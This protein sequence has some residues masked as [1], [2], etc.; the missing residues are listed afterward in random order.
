[1]TTIYLP[2]AGS[3]ITFF[4]LDPLCTGSSLAMTFMSSF[5]GIH[6]HLRR[7]A[8]GIPSCIPRH[9]TPDYEVLLQSRG[10]INNRVLAINAWT[11]DLLMSLL[12]P[13]NL[14]GLKEH[15]QTADECESHL[16]PVHPTSVIHR[17][18]YDKIT[19]YDDIKQSTHAY[20][21][22]ENY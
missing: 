21:I 6:V 4:F 13:E 2:S 17:C 22:G 12:L 3:C 18:A 7:L 8:M 14:G 1:M 19:S 16:R 9:E 15:R 10:R 11:T 5:A 20:I